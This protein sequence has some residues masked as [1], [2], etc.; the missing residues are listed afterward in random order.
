MDQNISGIV[1]I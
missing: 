1:V